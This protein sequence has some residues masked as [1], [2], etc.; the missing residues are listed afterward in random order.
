MSQGRPTGN[1]ARAESAD[2]NSYQRDMVAGGRGSATS[3]REGYT[4]ACGLEYVFTMSAPPVYAIEHRTMESLQRFGRMSATANAPGI[5]STT[6]NLYPSGSHH[7]G[8]TV[9]HRAIAKTE[10]NQE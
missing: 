2:H 7:R 6:C 8:G 3:D 4:A 5:L 10:S 1:I 9:T